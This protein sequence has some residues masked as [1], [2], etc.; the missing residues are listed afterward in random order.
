MRIVGL[1]GEVAVGKSTVAKIIKQDLHVPVLNTDQLVH[2]LYLNDQSFKIELI[3]HFGTCDKNLISNYV[4]NNEKQRHILES[5]IHPRVAKR[6][7]LLIMWHFIL[8]HPIIIIEIPLF[9]KLRL[10][11]FFGCIEVKASPQMQLRR[12]TLRRKLKESKALKLIHL[13]KIAMRHSQ[14]EPSRYSCVSPIVTVNNFLSISKL[15][16]SIIDQDSQVRKLLFQRLWIHRFLYWILVIV[17]VIAYNTR[18]H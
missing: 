11:R 4:L 9:F 1:A 6:L 10:D 7:F 5:L 16:S 15:R 2:W 12:L 17:I 18:A 8:G 13:T 3:E 14:T